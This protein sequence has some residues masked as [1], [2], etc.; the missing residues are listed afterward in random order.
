MDFLKKRPLLTAGLILILVALLALGVFATIRAERARRE[1]AAL[2]AAEAARKEAEDLAFSERFRAALTDGAPHTGDKLVAYLAA[3]DRYALDWIPEAL[4]AGTP[5]EVGGV[6]EVRQSGESIFELRLMAV[7]K[8]YLTEEK[9][10]YAQYQDRR[11]DVAGAQ[12]EAASWI[13]ACWSGDQL[14][15]TVKNL[16]KHSCFGCGDK[17]CA[18]VDKGV[19]L[20]I[21]EILPEELRARSPWQIGAWVEVES[22]G[23]RWVVTYQPLPESRYAPHFWSCSADGAVD[24]TGLRDWLRQQAADAALLQGFCD[25]LDAGEELGGG[26]KIIGRYDGKY[27]LEDIPSELRAS[28][29][30][31]VGM[32]LERGSSSYDAYLPGEKIRLGEISR[33]TVDAEGPESLKAFMLQYLGRALVLHEADALLESGDVDPS[34]RK[35]LS[36][37]D[38]GRYGWTYLPDE[39]RA[40]APEELRGILFLEKSYRDSSAWYTGEDGKAVNIALRLETLSVR[41]VDLRSG[42]TVAARTFSATTPGTIITSSADRTQTVEVDWKTVEDWVSAVWRPAA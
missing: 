31:E 34:A 4:Q 38:D 33:K 13:E 28:T 36:R 27:D 6:V 24:L 18:V 1:A 11:Y 10:F 3:E 15:K 20:S 9:T 19:P 26:V 29:P 17:I 39:L 21:G 14:S 35:L 5:E 23:S 32:I 22:W 42:Q 40:V 37:V 12:A 16:E 7:G 30:S 2:G 41:L 25:A 8:P